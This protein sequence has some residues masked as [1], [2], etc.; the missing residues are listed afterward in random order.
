MGDKRKI[1]EELK[2]SH[3]KR[4]DDKIIV[5]VGLTNDDYNLITDWMEEVSNETYKKI[6]ERNIELV[7]SITYLMQTMHVTVK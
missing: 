1:F 2:R 5:T 7:R 4:K 3:K 6:D